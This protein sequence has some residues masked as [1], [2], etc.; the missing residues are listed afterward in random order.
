MF[1]HLVVI[2]SDVF[3]KEGRSYE[4]DLAEKYWR[5]MLGV[6]EGQ[7]DSSLIEFT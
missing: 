1:Y 3:Q 6:G 2:R 7:K 5:E 4:G